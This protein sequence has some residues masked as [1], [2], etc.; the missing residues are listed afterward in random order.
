MA[1]NSYLGAAKEAKNDDRIV[2]VDGY[3][4]VVDERIL[5]FEKHMFSLSSDADRSVLFREAAQVPEG[6]GV[7]VLTDLGDESGNYMADTREVAELPAP[8][9]DR[10][11]AALAA[12]GKET[13]SAT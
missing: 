8:V 2:D 10:I 6:G 3:V 12:L 7:R 4:H 9:Q 5:L 13:V 11:R 1:S